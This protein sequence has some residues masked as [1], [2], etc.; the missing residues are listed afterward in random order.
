MG[1]QKKV[2]ENVFSQCFIQKNGKTYAKQPISRNR[3]TFQ[4]KYILSVFEL[5]T[6]KKRAKWC[7]A[8]KIGK[9]NDITRKVYNECF[10]AQNNHKAKNAKSH[11]YGEVSQI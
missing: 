10:I 1:I 3:K 6:Y 11:V 8:L 4:K 5:V 2:T 9:Q 7:K